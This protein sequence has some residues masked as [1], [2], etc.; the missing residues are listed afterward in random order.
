MKTLIVINSSKF[1]TYSQREM[2]MKQVINMYEICLSMMHL[3][4]NEKS[5]YAIAKFVEKMQ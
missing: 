2:S 5:K 4:N 1:G 3:D